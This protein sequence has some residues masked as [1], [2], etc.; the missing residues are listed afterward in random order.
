M[1]RAS[2]FAHDRSAKTLTRVTP[3]QREEWLTSRGSIPSQSGVVRSIRCR[4][5]YG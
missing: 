1:R 3:A 5:L 4:R 2:R